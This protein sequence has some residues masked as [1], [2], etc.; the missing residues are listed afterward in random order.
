MNAEKYLQVLEEKLLRS[1]RDLYGD[2]DWVFQQDNAP[3]HTAKRCQ[4]WFRAQGI[5]VLEWPAQSPDL[6][7]IENLWMQ[8]KVLV[9]KDKPSTKTTLI[10]AIIKAW[11]KV[12]TPE[13]LE[14]LVA[15]MPRRCKAVIEAKGWPTKY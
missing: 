7:P 9:A 11:Y 12:I 5:S 8:I 1:A 4:N 15:S 2:D 14:S 6:N 13:R 3:C 10:E